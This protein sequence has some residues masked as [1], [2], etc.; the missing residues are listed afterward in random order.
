VGLGN[1]HASSVHFAVLFCLTGCKVTS[2]RCKVHQHTAREWR[3]EMDRISTAVFHSFNCVAWDVSDWGHWMYLH[4]H[5]SYCVNFNKKY[6]R[7]LK[8][9]FDWWVSKFNVAVQVSA[10]LYSWNVKVFCSKLGLDICIPHTSVTSSVLPSTCRDKASEFFAT[11]S[12]HIRSNL[13]VTFHHILLKNNDYSQD[14]RLRWVSSTD[15]KH[16]K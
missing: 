6:T 7:H 5:W 15:T 2:R 13:F 4:I 10:C 16:I 9:G 1:L 11:T 14:K 8:Q 12:F 3:D